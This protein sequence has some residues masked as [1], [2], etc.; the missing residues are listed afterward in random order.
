MR[1]RRPHRNDPYAAFDI[2]VIAASAGGIPALI[3][4]LENLPRSFP[5]PIIV[6]QHLPPASRYA[7]KLDNVLRSRTALQVKWAE[8]GERPLPGTVYLA[9]QDR[10]T[11]LNTQTGCLT[12]TRAGDAKV[13]RPIADPLFCSVAEIFG[14][15]AMAVVLS[16]ALSDGAAGSAAIA[17]AGGRVLA[18]TA[19]EAQFDDMPSAAMKRSRVGL[20]FDSIS[21]ACVI[22]NLVMI[23]GVAAWFGIGKA[24]VGAR[25]IANFA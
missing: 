11:V 24:G 18:Q 12:V 23:P 4:F 19:S 3:P 22:G 16:G 8:D 15:R 20:P 10:N 5:I 7:S 13:A 14:S 1:S 21:L 6:V 17:C 25:E 2:V 9:P